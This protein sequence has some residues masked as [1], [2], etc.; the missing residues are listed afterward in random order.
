MEDK[1]IYEIREMVVNIDATLKGIVAN[2]DLKFK[3]QDEKIKVANNRISDLVE[4]N[5]WLWRTATTTAVGLIGTL[6][7]LLLKLK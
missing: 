6:A 1:V 2:T 3:M 4:T 5:K 7:M